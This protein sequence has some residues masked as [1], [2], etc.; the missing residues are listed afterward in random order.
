[1]K[2]VADMA[3]AWIIGMDRT[4]RSG[5]KTRRPFS[6]RDNHKASA[7]SASAY[8]M[9]EICTSPPIRVTRNI[10]SRDQ[11]FLRRPSNGLSPALK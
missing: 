10:F 7:M 8:Q 11:R 2:D 6:E 9:M 3:A 4:A 1:M 5:V